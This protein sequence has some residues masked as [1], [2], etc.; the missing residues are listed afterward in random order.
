MIK[1]KLVLISAIVIIALQLFTGCGIPK[2]E[3]DGAIAQLRDSQSQVA[4][5]QNEVR[6]SQAQLTES[7]NEVIKLRE[8]YELAGKIPSETAEKIVKR[9]HETHVYTEPDFYVCADM[10][11]DVWDMLK[12]QGINAIVQIGRV[13]RDAKDI[14]DSD[15]AWVLAET[16]PGKYLALETTGGFAVWDNALYYKGWSF[17]NPR[18]YK[19]FLELRYEYNV[20]VKIVKQLADTFDVT[21]TNALRAADELRQISNEVGKLSVFDPSL[22][23]EIVKLLEKATQCGEYT[24]KGRLLNELADKQNLELNRIVSEMKGLVD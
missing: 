11:L 4:A 9:Y 2:N 16:S 22:G 13:D 15:H 12:A 6:T 24:G 23:S 21:R 5:L 8:Q 19:R 3:Y 18:E 14:T 10:A 20:R 17:H 1:N 7:K